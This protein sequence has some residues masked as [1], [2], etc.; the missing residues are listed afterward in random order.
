MC[1]YRYMV[2]Y[3]CSIY[4]VSDVC[5]Y[6]YILRLYSASSR[7]LGDDV[8]CAV[9]CCVAKQRASVWR[10]PASLGIQE[11]VFGYLDP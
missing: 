8:D 10:Q 2:E 6:I 3:I 5:V 11:V 1:I 9:L 4:I 7:I